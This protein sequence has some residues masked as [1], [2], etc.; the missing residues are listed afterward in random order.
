MVREARQ[1]AGDAGRIDEL[2]ADSL[3]LVAGDD[4]DA[5]HAACCRALATRADVSMPFRVCADA[6]RTAS[7]LGDSDVY[8]SGAGNHA[9]LAIQEAGLIAT[10][11]IANFS[12]DGGLT[13]LHLCVDGLPA[14]ETETELRTIHRFVYT[15]TRA[16]SRAGSGCHVHLPAD[17]GGELVDTMAPLFDTVIE[18]EDGHRYRVGPW[19]DE[20]GP[21]RQLSERPRG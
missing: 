15:L 3:L 10:E 12:V 2:P 21:W 9:D 11:S 1:W 14:P 13:G 17:G 7:V 20:C 18:L 16:V 19:D 8:D 4:G 5:S 6:T